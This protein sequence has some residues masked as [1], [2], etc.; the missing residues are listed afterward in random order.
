[1]LFIYFLSFL[2]G[3][4]STG[5]PESLTNLYNSFDTAKNISVLTEY[6]GQIADYYDDA[7][8]YIFT[9]TS[10]GKIQIE[11]LTSSRFSLYNSSRVNVN[12]S[13]AYPKGT[14]YLKV[15]ESGNYTF[16]VVATPTTIDLS[17]A[18]VTLE[19]N[20][21][22]YDGKP[23]CPKVRVEYGTKVLVEGVDYIVE[24]SKNVEVDDY[25]TVTITGIGEY[26]GT[27]T[28]HFEIA[29]KQLSK[30]D[31]FVYKGTTYKLLSD[32]RLSLTS[33][34]NKNIK[35]ITIPGSISYN[36][37][38]YYVTEIGKKA[39]SGC[40]K[41]SKVTIQGNN[42]TKIR[43]KAFYKC[44]KL[45]TVNISSSELKY[46]GK[47]AFKGTNKKIKVKISYGYLLSKYRKLFKK[48]G[49]KE[50]NIVSW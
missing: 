39:F 28:E 47:Q 13:N 26:S 4:L 22:Y 12:Y 25:A 30:G 6:K 7:D 23:K 33:V 50:S 32:S 31:T 36:G 45:K 24:Y 17:S 1:M 48:G 15:S 49:L 18:T 20:T 46:V 27:I 10:P 3:D 29:Y 34:G 38:Y 11:G 35:N 41:L 43:E 2:H 42:F 8:Y 40:K 21:V 5:F 19:Y 37:S 16:R 44:K 14:Y 9:L